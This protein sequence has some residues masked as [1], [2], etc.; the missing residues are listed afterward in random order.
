LPF[1]I[2]LALLHS[3]LGASLI[4][5][6]Q[7]WELLQTA[8]NEYYNQ[9]PIL[10]SST[11][12]PLTTATTTKKTTDMKTKQEYI[13]TKSSMKAD[14]HGYGL[15][16]E[17][18]DDEDKD[19]PWVWAIRD[20]SILDAIWQ[21]Q[22]QVTS[23]SSLEKVKQEQNELP[24]WIGNNIYVGNRHYTADH[25]DQ[26]GIGFVLNMA[27]P[28]AVKNTVVR[29]MQLR[30]IH[31]KTIPAKDQLGYPLLKLHW[32]E[33]HEFIC[34]SPPR[35]HGG[36]CRRWL[37]WFHWCWCCCCSTSSRSQDQHCSGSDSKHQHSTTNTNNNNKSHSNKQNILIHCVA[38]QNRS[39]LI[40]AVEYM[41]QNQSTVL[42]TMLHIRRTRGSIA[43]HNT[44]FQE[45]LVQMARQ[46]HLLGPAPGTSGCIVQ[47]QPP[48]PPPPR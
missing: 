8:L 30:G 26:L 34:N 25:L 5:D 13:P 32:E 16:E 24:I 38:G 42:E 47:T 17:E 4:L 6:A 33:A 29:T 7:G 41:L 20:T 3:S 43:L 1:T 37:H 39:V 11:T 48:P 36:R 22:Q 18:E 9:P 14:Q 10:L 45:E 46:H 19:W 21:E 35:N 44:S 40:A 23:S 15:A 31:Y 12:T 2:P 28:M 27:G